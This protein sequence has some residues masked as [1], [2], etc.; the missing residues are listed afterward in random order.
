[1]FYRVR[2]CPFCVISLYN[3]K[4]TGIFKD[5]NR[6]LIR[7]ELS[8]LRPGDLPTAIKGHREWNK[9]NDCYILDSSPA[10]ETYIEVEYQRRLSAKYF[11]E[12]LC[13]LI[14][15]T[16]ATLEL[17]LA[18]DTEK[19]NR[20]KISHTIKNIE[21]KIK[22]SD[23][24]S[25]ANASDISPNEAEI[26]KQNPIRSFADNMTLQR[27]YLWRTYA[28]GDIGMNNDNWIKLCDKDF[29]EKYNN[30]EP[31]QYFRRL[32]YYRRQVRGLF[33][34]VRFSG[35]DDTKILSGDDVIKVFKQSQEKIVKIRENALLLFGFKTRAKGIPDLNATIKFIN[36]IVNNWCGY[37]IKS[38]RR[39]EGPKG[40]QVWKST[41]WI[42]RKPYN[43]TGFIIQEEIMDMKSLDPN[44]YPITP[45]LPSYKPESV[46]ETQELFDSIPITTDI[47]S[48]EI[49]EESSCNNIIPESLISLSSEF[50]IK[51]ESDIDMIIL[52]LQQKFQISQEK[53]EQWRS[54]IV[55]KIRD[56]QKY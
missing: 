20:N 56:N 34:S 24:E 32:A 9:I 30:P 48:N 40:Q 43:G 55:F 45:I 52:L 22:S 21:K 1:M 4:K 16:G 49:C 39:K 19:V 47:A 18:E 44:Y 11:P 27:H 31:L 38:R 2:D 26:L 41:Y 53:L 50:L 3:S 7:A 33:Q 6:D 35:I 13:S 23:A 15:S 5:P 10:V 42:D 36:T 29:V 12:I 8:A 17:I 54:K 28:S 14:A 51:N 37:T 46:N 25:I